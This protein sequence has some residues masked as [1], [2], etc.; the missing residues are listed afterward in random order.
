MG[1]AGRKKGGGESAFKV[2]KSTKA[3]I[4]RGRTGILAGAKKVFTKRKM[5][6]K[7]CSVILEA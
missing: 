7:S 1:I 3:T 6:N 5:Q 4:D 2:R